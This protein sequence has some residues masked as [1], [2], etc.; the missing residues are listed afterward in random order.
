[1][2]TVG[3]TVGAIPG[4]PGA[5]QTIWPTQVRQTIPPGRRT[6]LRGRGLR[7]GLR[8]GRGLR[9]SLR[10]GRVLP[11]YRGQAS[12][13]C[14]PRSAAGPHH[15]PKYHRSHGSRQGHQ[16]RQ[17]QQRPRRARHAGR[18]Q[19]LRTPPHPDLPLFQ[20]P[21]QTPGT[22]RAP[23]GGLASYRGLRQ[24]PS[25]RSLSPSPGGYTAHEFCYLRR[26]THHIAD[27]DDRG[28]PDALS[29]HHAFH[30]FQ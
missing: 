2:P 11:V 17:P 8:W 25:T 18:L 20:R 12:R 28:R 19:R 30:L 7:R 27:H 26:D 29:C 23:R 22:P 15:R 10:W 6:I 16:S 13:G 4:V 24:S 5:R 21:P 14:H 3:A 1:M 9:R